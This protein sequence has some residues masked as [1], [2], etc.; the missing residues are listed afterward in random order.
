M[1][2][3]FIEKYALFTDKYS[4]IQSDLNLNKEQF[5]KNIE[6]FKYEIEVAR[7]ARQICIR[8][9]ITIEKYR[10]FYYWYKNAKRVCHYCKTQE[11]DLDFFF[12][13]LDTV[14]KRPKRGKT[15]EIDRRNPLILDYDNIQNLV[16]SCYI[17]N[18]AKSDIFTEDEFMPIALEIGKTIQKALI[19]KRNG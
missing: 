6:T 10:N 17:C 14:N 8:K 18:N 9:G 16:L 4:V 12:N 5:Y 7:K 11:K 15:L 2:D 3:E 19:T 13:N 1:K